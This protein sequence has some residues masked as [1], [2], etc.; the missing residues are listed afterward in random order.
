MQTLTKKS[1]NVRK[2]FTVDTILSADTKVTADMT[3]VETLSLLP[4]KR[5]QGSFLIARSLACTE[6][7]LEAAN[8]R[9]TASAAAIKLR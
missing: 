4:R 6:R 9:D 8:T 7:A 1:Q 2:T 3:P 5:L